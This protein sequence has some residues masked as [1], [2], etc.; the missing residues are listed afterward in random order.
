[1]KY[2]HRITFNDYRQQLTKIILIFNTSSTKTKFHI[3][4]IAVIF[5]PWK[6]SVEVVLNFFQ[7]LVKSFQIAPKMISIWPIYIKIKRF[8]FMWTFLNNHIICALLK[9]NI[10]RNIWDFQQLLYSEV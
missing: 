2:N 4:C 10:N 6:L 3:I 5:A 9:L 8:K 1:M 7:A